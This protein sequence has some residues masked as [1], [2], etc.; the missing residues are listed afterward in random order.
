[1][2]WLFPAICGGLVLALAASF[3]RAQ[4]TA[5]ETEPITKG[6]GSDKA[7]PGSAD[8]TTPAARTDGP[9]AEDKKNA[10]DDAAPKRPVGGRGGRSDAKRADV[11]KDAPKPE[12]AEGEIKIFKLLHA[13]AISSEETIMRLYV[14]ALHSG[15][16]SM[17][18]DTRTNSLI[19]RGPSELLSTIEAVLLTLDDAATV[20]GDDAL[21]PE[22]AGQPD[23]P[24]GK[25][26][27]DRSPLAAE[28]RQH[29]SLAAG[30]AAAYRNEQTTSR[31]DEQKLRQLK[32]QLREA[33]QA[34]F[35]VR[36]KLQRA[37]TDRLR[38]R[39]AQIERQIGSR[40]Q[41]AQEI[42]DTRVEELLHPEKEW[43][44]GDDA[45]DPPAG[46]QRPQRERPRQ[47]VVGERTVSEEPR[48]LTRGSGPSQPER[49]ADPL[50]REG[51]PN[52][53]KA[54]LDAEAAIA[55]A[56]ARATDANMACIRVNARANRI[57][58]LS[59]KGAV[60]QEKVEAVEEELTAEQ[61]RLERAMLDQEQAERQAAL[62][63]EDL[64]A[65]VE[66]LKFDLDA[67]AL[68]FEQASRDDARTQKLVEQRAI[69]SE[70]ADQKAV[71]LQQ[72]RLKYQR[73]KTLYG[74]YRKALPEGGSPEGKS[75]APEDASPRRA[76]REGQTDQRAKKE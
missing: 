36:Q 73:A 1:M 37:E 7:N 64:A 17:S 24:K 46:A 58:E 68:N 18:A 47:P 34:A 11:A 28:Y 20:A 2:K 53:R 39:L 69:S 70:E 54:L 72:A 43:N 44:A 49:P 59:K 42:I 29:E 71:A 40:Q 48:A 57:R 10:P 25:F 3:P 55:A 4:D 13:P 16:L 30:L 6:A 63:R 66:L 21:K 32:T 15:R 22:A 31:P 35:D 41:R 14:D 62:A 75:A 9:R 61:N 60:S 74:L 33:V 8:E 50:A 5:T 76:P 67:A 19:M 27:P 56:R 51:T 45:S 38:E 12:A 23:V 52:Y 26:R 65:Q